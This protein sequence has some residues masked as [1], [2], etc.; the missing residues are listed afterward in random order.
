MMGPSNTIQSFLQRKID[1]NAQTSIFTLVRAT[2][3]KYAIKSEA[4]VEYVSKF[5]LNDS[6]L[7]VFSTKEGLYT[8][9][10]IEGTNGQTG[11][12]KL[13][14][15]KEFQNRSMQEKQIEEFQKEFENF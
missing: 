3:A 14:I 10:K 4:A 5:I 1:E 9:K 15:I 12:E 13:Q 8:S 11:D 6:H 7:V 2:M